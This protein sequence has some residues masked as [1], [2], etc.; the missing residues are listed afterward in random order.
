M[1]IEECNDRLIYCNP[2]INPLGWTSHF[3]GDYTTNSYDS[4]FVKFYENNKKRNPDNDDLKKL[5]PMLNL[6]TKIEKKVVE[7]PENVIKATTNPILYH[8]GE[9]VAKEP[10]KLLRGVL[11]PVGS[12]LNI[13]SVNQ[14]VPTSEKIPSNLT[15]EERQD[16]I[17]EHGGGLRCPEK[18]DNS[19]AIVAG[20]CAILAGLAVA[21]DCV[22][23]KGKHVKQITKAFKKNTKVKTAK[24][25]KPVKAVKTVKAHANIRGRQFTSIQEAE[26]HFRNMG[27]DVDLSKCRDLRQLTQ[28][29]AELAKIKAMGIESQVKSITVTPFDRAS[30]LKATRARGIELTENVHSGIYGYSD[31]G[32]IFLNSNGNGFRRMAN[33]SD[34]I[35]H[36]IGH[37]HRNVLKDNVYGAAE[38]NNEVF[39][40]TVRSIA[41]KTNMTTEQVIEK[42]TSRLHSEVKAYSP[43][44]DESFADMFSLMIDG[45]QYS[46]GAMLFYDMAGG[47]RIPNKVINGIKYDDYIFNLYEDAENILMNYIR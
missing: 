46:K 12:V 1:G 24:T 17:R 3:W 2:Y 18:S 29:D 5:F 15:T 42:L 37:Y 38:G 45:K 23:A 31:K 22:F 16:Y 10:S 9:E 7:N 20:G 6:T 33:G 11:G 8:A 26:A 13:G 34:T 47:G 27:I 32:H 19:A 35:K 14:K 4:P 41:Q 43:M 36:E 39:S 30:M 25:T 21:A 44:A 40:A 28:I